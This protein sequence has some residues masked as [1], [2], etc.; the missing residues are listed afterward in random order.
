[1][2]G[3]RCA[4]PLGGAAVH[5]RTCVAECGDRVCGDD[6][7][8]GSCGSC[9]GAAACVAGRCDSVE[10]ANGPF[11]IG[12]GETVPDLRLSAIPDAIRSVDDMRVLAL[13]EYYTPTTPG[14]LAIY[15]TTGWA[16]VDRSA[17]LVAWAKPDASV[18]LL[19]I[20]LEG[21]RRGQPADVGNLQEFA[22]RRALAVPVAMDTLAQLPGSMRDAPR[23]QLL[24]VDRTTM[25]VVASIDPGDAKAWSEFIAR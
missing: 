18:E 21:E 10:Y 13:A 19:I 3:A 15:V 2:F 20:L 11:G 17:E 9:E 6:G 14:T 24:L 22:K 23:A 5:E 7:C 12:L 4:R 1:V 8:G 25:K 16:D